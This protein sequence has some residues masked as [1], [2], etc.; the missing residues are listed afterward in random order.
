MSKLYSYVVVRDYGFAPNPFFGFCTLA[1]CKPEI[2]RTASVGDWIMGTGS[3]A[4]G[5]SAHV[6][7]AM[8]V[9]ETMSFNQYWK[10]PRFHDKRPDMHA[11]IRNA[12][13]DNIYCHN[14]VT[15]KWSQLDSHHSC[16]DGTSNPENIR[17]DTRVDRVLVSDHF[18]YWGGSG[19][20]IPTSFGDDICKRGSG[21]RCHFPDELVEGC[22]A[23]LRSL[24]ETGYCSDPS[25]WNKKTMPLP[26][27]PRRRVPPFTRGA[28]VTIRAAIDGLKEFRQSHRLNGLSVRLMIQEGRRY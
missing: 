17:H 20:S 6:V 23:W 12:F 13:G 5:R 18:T 7:Y 27:N 3:K 15:D 8:R 2:R 26:W 10:D 19:P 21:H 9:S 14:D 24:N 11:S 4:K 25:D 16:Q 1:T 28:A 22:I